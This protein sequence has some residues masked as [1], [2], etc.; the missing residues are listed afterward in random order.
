MHNRFRRRN[1]THIH[2][3]QTQSNTEPPPVHTAIHHSEGK[4]QTVAQGATHRVVS[5][6]YGRL[7]GGVR[8]H[9][10]N[11]CLPLPFLVDLSKAP[12]GLSV[13]GLSLKVLLIFIHIVHL[14]MTGREGE[15]EGSD[16]LHLRSRL[17]PLPPKTTHTYPPILHLWFL[18][19]LLPTSY[20][21]HCIKIEV[22]VGWTM[23]TYVK[24]CSEHEKRKTERGRNGG[25]SEEFGENE[26]DREREKG[27]TG[28]S[29]VE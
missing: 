6:G 8:I 27:A 21:S 12:T 23:H 28:N 2:T 17:P 20:P 9:G 10:V 18:H 16:C 26:G 7:S 3:A 19:H 22:C 5:P 14:E 1:S 25:L 11:D 24:G 13:R 29:L 15:R 4:H